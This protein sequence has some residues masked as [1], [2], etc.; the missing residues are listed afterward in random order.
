MKYNLNFLQFMS[1]D[2]VTVDA[3]LWRKGFIM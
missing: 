1:Q 2:G 3:S